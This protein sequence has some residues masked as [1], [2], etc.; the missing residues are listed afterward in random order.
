MKKLH[1]LAFYALVTPTIALGSGL[2]LAEQSTTKDGVEKQQSTQ[3]EKDAMK[4]ENK[5]AQTDQKMGD[6]SGMQNKG[7][8]ATAPAG[9]MRA[10]DL[11]GAEIT[12]TGNEEVGEVSE[13]L[14]DKDGQVVAVVVGV[15]G[16]LGL[17]EKDVAIGWDEVTKT[18]ESGDVELKIDMTREELTSAPGYESVE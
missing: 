12:T 15:G 5:S 9:G 6:H 3:H 17:G 13:L 1:S 18:S 10:S 8:M 11:I 7:Y 2:L 4:S 16:F 14:I